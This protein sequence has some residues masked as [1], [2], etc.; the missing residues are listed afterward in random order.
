MEHEPSLTVLM[1]VHDADTFIGA[2]LE[3]VLTQTYADIEVVVVDDASADS[4]PEILAGVSDPRLR[5]LRLER[6]AGIAAALNAA[7]DEARGRYVARMD[8]DDVALPDR[9]ERQV[10][11]LER[12]PS[13]GIVGGNLQPIDVNGHPLGPPTSVPTSPG[14]V[15]WMLHVHNSVNHP[16]V[17]ARRSVLVGLGGY[18]SDAE[19]AEDYDLWVR[20]LE[21]TRIANVPEVVVR[22]RVHGASTSARSPGDADRAAN[23]VAA[24]AL[25]RLLGRAPDPDALRV[26]RDAARSE[27]SPTEHLRAASS[28]L[29]RFTRAVLSDRTLPREDRTWIRRD[30]IIWF[31]SLFRSAA[32]HD[33]VAAATLAL[34]GPDGPP[35]WALAGGA[36]AAGRK[37]IRSFT[38]P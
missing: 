14:H 3:S 38:R 34:P 21:V 1:P 23:A 9:L 37:V 19:P 12:D 15:R 8:A 24:E 27:G 17:V 20:A 5:I 7:L 33:P 13:I 22:Y 11:A 6:S 35:A 4:T 36:A 31:G 18:R 25:T 2:S 10:A 16:T 30:A 29:W 28:L 26:L 32:R